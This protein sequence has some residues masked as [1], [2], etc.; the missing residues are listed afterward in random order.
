MGYN[1]DKFFIGISSVGDTFGTGNEDEPWLQY[2]V[3]NFRMFIGRRFS[4]ENWF[5]KKKAQP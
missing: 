5:G 1:S 3:N 2:S 4:V